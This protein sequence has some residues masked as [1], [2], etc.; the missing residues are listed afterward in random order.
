MDEKHPSD[1]QNASR[2][3]KSTGDDDDATD[4]GAITSTFR[5]L[6]N[7]RNRSA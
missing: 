1:T 2:K 7:D 5:A 4:E 3:I 6:G